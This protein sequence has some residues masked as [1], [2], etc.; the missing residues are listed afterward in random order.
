[1][2]L[3]RAEFSSCFCSASFKVI[4]AWCTHIH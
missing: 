3:S 2:T 1:M 4:P